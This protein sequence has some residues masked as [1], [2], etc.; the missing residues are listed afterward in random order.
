MNIKKQSLDQNIL[1]P[2]DF[3]EGCKQMSAEAGYAFRQILRKRFN[4]SDDKYLND[5]TKE[6]VKLLLS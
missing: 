4:V 6:F 3:I 2:S 5:C 1:S